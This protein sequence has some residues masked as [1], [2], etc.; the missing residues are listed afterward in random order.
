MTRLLA[1][2]LM[3]LTRS[4]L[5]Q[6]SSQQPAPGI[7]FVKIVPGEFMMGCSAG[8]IDCNADERPIHLVQITKPLEMGK[9][10]VTQAQWKAV[11]GSNPSTMKGDDRPVETISKSE[12]Q[13]F[14][15]RLN[16]HNDGFHYRLP[17][18]AEWEYA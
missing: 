15:N 8:D 9:Y 4:L 18:E 3:L 5:A 1:A 13:D 14:L 11:M 12:A 2:T 16:E 6:T 17:T 7:D 10:E